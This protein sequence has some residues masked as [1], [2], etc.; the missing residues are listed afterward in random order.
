MDIYAAS[1]FFII[2]MLQLRKS[3]YCIFE[4]TAI[5]F[6]KIDLGNIHSS[7]GM[8]HYKFCQIVQYRKYKNIVSWYLFSGNYAHCWNYQSF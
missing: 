1:I 2:L 8:H 5:Y 4:Q 7:V 6:Y 3:S